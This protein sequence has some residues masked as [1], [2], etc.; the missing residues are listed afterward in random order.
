MIFGK[1]K[2]VEDEGCIGL[3]RRYQGVARGHGRLKARIRL[4][5]S[6]DLGA[7]VMQSGRRKEHLSQRVFWELSDV[8]RIQVPS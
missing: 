8:L 2:C 1:W 4:L 6:S 5:M 7:P 3:G